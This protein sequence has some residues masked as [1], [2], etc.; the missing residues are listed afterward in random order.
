MKKPSRKQQDQIICFPFSSS[1][2]LALW[3]EWK[4]Y[5][6]MQ[7]KLNLAPYSEQRQLN[8]LFNISGRNEEYAKAIINNSMDNVWRSFYEIKDLKKHYKL[9]QIDMDSVNKV[10]TTT[11]L[12][13]KY[14]Q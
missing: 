6:K 2:F 11:D 4:Q 14:E 8:K 9:Y 1:E 7:F 10:Q 3:V 12:L 5:L 13:K